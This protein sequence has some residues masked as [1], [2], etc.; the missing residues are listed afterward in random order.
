MKED[1]GYPVGG[2]IITE[3]TTKSQKNESIAA[4]LEQMAFHFIAWLWSL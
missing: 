1:A 2:E 3:R 4:F